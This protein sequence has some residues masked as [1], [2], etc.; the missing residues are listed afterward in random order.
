M[1]GDALE[2]GGGTLGGKWV[3]VGVVARRPHQTLALNERLQHEGAAPNPGGG[4]EQLPY[5]P[6]YRFDFRPHVFK[7][8]DS[9]LEDSLERFGQLAIPSWLNTLAAC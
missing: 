3:T 9:M 5:S 2:V 1:S 7:S 4:T 8:S 6:G